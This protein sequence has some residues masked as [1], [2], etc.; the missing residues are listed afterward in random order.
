[1][2]KAAYRTI[3]THGFVLDGQGQKMSKSKKNIIEPQSIIKQSG[4][5][6]L[7]LWVASTNYKNDV[8]IDHSILKQ[9][10][11]KYRKIRNTLRFML[12]NL[13]D[14]NIQ[15]DYISF[16]KRTTLHKLIVLEFK[17]IIKQIIE[18][19]ETYNF[20]KIISLIYPFITTKISAFYLD[21]AKDILYIEMP[22]CKER[23]TIQSNIYDLLLD[24]L[25]IL[26]PI[27]PHTTSEA[28]S[29]LNI[30]ERFK[31]EDIYLENMPTITQI[32]NF[33]D[34]FKQQDTNSEEQKAYQKFL[35]LRDLILKKLEEARKNQI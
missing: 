31:K 27:I 22:N 11:E 17:Q 23:R 12:G 20:E 1:F 19:Y 15:T 25:I 35:D 5:D 21:F 28:Y 6:I 26:T 34:T 4:A 10:E 8:R 29:Y 16:Q 33:I 14:F 7:R 3:I 2:N 13:Y 18:A 9:I 24:L 32:D 30:N